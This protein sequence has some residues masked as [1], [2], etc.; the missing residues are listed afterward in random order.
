MNRLVT[1]QNPEARPTP[2]LLLGELRDIDPTVE[3]VYAG[4][5]RWWLGA[6]SDNSERRERA[7]RMMK[8]IEAL[9]RWQQSA[10]TVMLCKLNLQGFALIETYIGNDPSGVVTV[11]PGPDEYQTTI[12]EDFRWRDANWRRDQ[13][14][15]HV[16]ARMLDTMG[17]AQRV[18]SE[19]KMKEYL[20]NDGRDQYRRIVQGRTSFGFGGMTGGD[21][22]L[23]IPAR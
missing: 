12:L 10:R 9:E 4:E 23:I 16:K 22:A 5:R 15:E 8:Q 14:S 20:A 21:R 13:G 1:H 17:E 19:A 2:L 11:N 7:E 3:L 18:E 6:V